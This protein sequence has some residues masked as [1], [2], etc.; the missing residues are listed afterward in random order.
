MGGQL[1]NAPNTRLNFIGEV[2]HIHQERKLFDQA[3][4]QKKPAYPIPD[5][6]D[7]E[8]K[9]ANRIGF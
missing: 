6:S 3:T 9:I 4:R 1:Q 5:H 8:I 7:T 2:Q